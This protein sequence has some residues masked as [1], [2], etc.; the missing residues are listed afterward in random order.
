[1]EYRTERNNRK[2][3]ELIKN[4]LRALV[5][6]MLGLIA[7]ILFTKEDAKEPCVIN[8]INNVAQS[9]NVCES[10]KTLPPFVKRT[11]RKGTHKHTECNPAGE[12]KIPPTVQDK[13]VNTVPEPA[14]SLLLGAG[15]VGLLVMRKKNDK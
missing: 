2:R 10:K 14:T 7:W 12:N 3:L 4:S 13:P 5:V 11:K 15:A 8:V 9:C 6:L 1:M